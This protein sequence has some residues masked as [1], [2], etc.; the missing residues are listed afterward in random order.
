MNAEEYREYK[1]ATRPVR[2]RGRKALAVLA[3][4]PDEKGGI[5]AWQVVMLPFRITGSEKGQLNFHGGYQFFRFFHTAEEARE[6]YDALEG[7]RPND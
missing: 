2:F 5:M 6:Y 3:A 4:V 7:W 1:K